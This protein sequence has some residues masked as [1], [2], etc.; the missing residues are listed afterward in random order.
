MFYLQMIEFTFFSWTLMLFLMLMHS[1]LGPTSPLF[2]PLLN[3]MCHKTTSHVKIWVWRKK[4]GNKDKKKN[5]GVSLKDSTIQ[6]T[7]FPVYT[8]QCQRSVYNGTYWVKYH[9]KLKFNL[10]LMPLVPRGIFLRTIPLHLPL[11]LALTSLSARAID[12]FSCVVT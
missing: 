6:E 7:L 12:L 8:L 4:K 10:V 3:R 11:P 2:W 5:S 9:K 1:T